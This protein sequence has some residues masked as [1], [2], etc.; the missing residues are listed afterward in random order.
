MC[1]RSKSSGPG[2]EHRAAHE[3]Y[4]PAGADAAGE[5]GHHSERELRP[6]RVGV[7]IQGAV[8]RVGLDRRRRVEFRPEPG[9][10][11]SMR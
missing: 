9:P 3:A 5:P 10:G 6:G 1:P 7:G 11:R 4:P 8:E 2:T